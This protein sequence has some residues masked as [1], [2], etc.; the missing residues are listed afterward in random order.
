MEILTNDMKME[1]MTNKMKGVLCNTHSHTK[2]IMMQQ[3]RLAKVRLLRNFWLS[4]VV[5]N[6]KTKKYFYQGDEN[7]WGKKSLKIPG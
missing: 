3:K 5:T 7:Q 2:Y 4:S 1:I 6:Q